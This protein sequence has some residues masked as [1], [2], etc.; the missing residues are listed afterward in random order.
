[1]LPVLGGTTAVWATCMAFYQ[2]IL[3][4]GYAFA[5]FVTR[6]MSSRWQALLFV[7]LALAPLMILPF[8][9]PAGRVP[10]VERNPI[11]WLFMILT[12]VVGLPFFVMSTIAPTLQK[13]FAGIGHG[14]SGDP[15]FLYAASNVG[16]MLG[17]LSYPILIE[18]RFRLAEQSRLWEYGYGVLLILVVVCA[19]T[20]WRAPGQQNPSELAPPQRDVTTSVLSFRERLLWMALAFVPSSLMLGVTTVL[21]TEIPPIPMLWV[22]PL[23]VYLLSFILVFAKKP[24]ISYYDVAARMPLLILA[25]MIPLLLKASWPLLLEIPINLMTLF[26]VAVACHGELAKR[27]PATEHLTGFYLWIALGGVLGGVFN[28]IIA[29]LIFSTVLEFPLALICAALLL[30]IMIPAAKQPRFNW[31]DVALPFALGALAVILIRVPRKFG[32]EPGIIFH[33]IVFAPTMLVCLSFGKRPIRFVLGFAALLIAATGY[34][35]AYQ[36]IL[37]TQRSFYGINRVANDD[38]GKYRVYFSGKT[39]HGIQSLA[40]GR[41]REPL[42]YFSHSSPIGQVFAT[43]S[44]TEKLRAVGVAGLGAGTIACYAAPGEEFTFYEIDPVVER[45]ARDPRYFTFLRDCAPQARVVLGDARISLKNA[46]DRHF[47]MLVLDAFGGDAV[48]IHLLTREAV[49]LYLSKL[50]DHGIL[51]FNISNHYLHLQKVLGNVA[52]DAGLIALIQDDTTSLGAGKLP[53]TWV[54]MART[55][56]DLGALIG[57]PRWAVLKRDPKARVWTDDY[58]SLLTVFIWD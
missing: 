34:T 52:S 33:L 48:P 19:V 53:S 39:I 11:P 44:G 31:L 29:P 56:D 27:R 17:L 7:A 14:S 58:S 54:V 20:L 46:P 35:G 24:I 10:P 49:Q 32:V 38:T 47:S 45:I 16:S 57:D 55:K 6:R 8:G 5:N 3:L 37:S 4:A 22:L 15:Y 30:Q 18:P 9:F 25:G 50:D 12:I 28:A 36:H 13:W 51:V 1:T 26:V 23:A 43:F 21:T 41:N 40:P 2:A 42:T